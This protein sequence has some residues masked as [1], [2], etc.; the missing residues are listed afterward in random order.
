MGHHYCLAKSLSSKANATQSEHDSLRS[1]A[2]ATQSDHDT[3]YTYA[4][5]ICTVVN[6]VML[7]VDILNLDS[8]DK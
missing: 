3:I 1:K 2:N 5:H 4:P 6:C 8:R 7:T